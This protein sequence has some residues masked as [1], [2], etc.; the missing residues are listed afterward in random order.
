MHGRIDKA[1]I[2]RQVTV[3]GKPAMEYDGLRAAELAWILGR[4]FKVM[5]DADGAPNDAGQAGVAPPTGSN[6]LHELR[7]HQMYGH[8]AY[9]GVGFGVDRMQRLAS[10]AWVEALFE[11]KLYNN[12]INLHEI[13]LDSGYNT[14]MDSQAHMYKNMLVGCS[15]IDCTDMT[16][17]LSYM[18]HRN[19]PS[20]QDATNRALQSVGPPRM[21]G[22]FCKETGPFLRG[23]QVKTDIVSIPSMKNPNNPLLGEDVSRQLGTEM[24]FSALEIE[25]RRR[26]IM[27]W[28]PD[29]IV[30][31]KLEDGDPTTTATIDA[32][33][34]QMFNVAV[35]GPAISTTWTSDLR[36]SKME[37]QPMDKVF[38]V[39]VADLACTFG[40]EGSDTDPKKKRGNDAYDEIKNIRQK[41]D[42][43]LDAV[44]R[45]MRKLDA[46]EDT[47]TE[48]AEIE[49]LTVEINT[50]RAAL[51][52]IQNDIFTSTDGFGN[53]VSDSDF[54]IL[55]DVYKATKKIYDEVM[56]DT[57]KTKA[58]RDAI[59]QD[60]VDAK[61]ALD[62]ELYVKWTPSRLKEFANLQAR[63][64]SG[65]TV[66]TTAKLMNFRLARMTSSYMNNYSKWVPNDRNSRCGL[67]IGTFLDTDSMSTFIVGGWC[68][69]TV[70]DSAASRSTVGQMVRTAPCSMA[71]NINVNVEWWSA[72]KLFQSYMDRDGLVTSRGQISPSVAGVASETTNLY[73]DAAFKPS[74]SGNVNDDGFAVKSDDDTVLEEIEIESVAFGVNVRSAK[75][76]GQKS[77][78]QRRSSGLEATVSSKDDG[79]NSKKKLTKSKVSNYSFLLKSASI[80]QISSVGEQACVSSTPPTSSADAPETSA[81]RSRPAA[82]VGAAAA[83]RQSHVSANRETVSVRR[84]SAKK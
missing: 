42:E 7:D 35:S 58:D 4:R 39:V 5:K 14:S 45:R 65:H 40:V 29:G 21:Q 73:K 19:A 22:I 9:A 67:P 46:N 68:V 18:S 81:S 72:D 49:A 8:Q 70:L 61:K 43:R 82:S 33:M 25:M 12:S 76:A 79:E 56:N 51:A 6:S 26:N 41:I 60:L 75:V 77:K 36:D 80:N 16:F 74:Y 10:T 55:D 30:L 34:A 24:C 1:D 62:S 13:Y 31:S 64:R 83:V 59:A 3:D 17:V 32:R 66:V 54:I 50:A 57:S 23:M 11:Q 38:I 27:D 47:T 63:I 52:T 2:K 48:D 28:T 84:S 15:A 20:S 69:G 71:L 78:R 44:T 53:P 37:C